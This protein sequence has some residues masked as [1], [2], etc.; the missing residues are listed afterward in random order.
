MSILTIILITLSFSTFYTV[1]TARSVLSYVK[2]SR[3]GDAA[4]TVGNNISVQLQ[5]A[6]KD[7]ALI[8]GLPMVLEGIS[9]SPASAPAPE[10]AFPRASLGYMLNRAKAAYSYYESFWLMNEAGEAVAG[11]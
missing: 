9:L 4:M 11:L 8:A 3:I 6:G 7:M 2:S 10:D 5:R 1:R